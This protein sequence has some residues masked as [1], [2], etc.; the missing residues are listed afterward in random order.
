[1]TRF[2]TLAAGLMLAALLAAPSLVVAQPDDSGSTTTD[3]ADPFGSDPSFP[4]DSFPSDSSDA[5]PSDM[6]FDPDSGE[7]T[8][9]DEAFDQ[10]FNEDFG[11]APFDP[12]APPDEAIKA[13]LAVYGIAI[14]FGL[15]IG[16]AILALVCWLVSTPLKAIPEQYREM[17]PGQVWL[18][19]IPCFP[20]IWNF[21]VYQRI[22]KSFQN[23][24]AATGK[25]QFGDCGAQIGL[26]YA[27][28]AACSVV[29]CL[30]YLAGP[31]SLVL[32][33]IMLVKLWSLKGEVER[34][35]AG[36]GGEEG[37]RSSTLDI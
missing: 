7:F 25:T 20:L 18:L 1:M 4:T 9:D 14:V 27:I 26:W 15:I 19:M 34:D 6:T 5:F 23:Y 28:C 22:P 37:M 8:F 33:I 16:F 31:A 29:P 30:N 12:N 11:N 35:L 21:F 32:L 10:Q 24:F 36:G 3:P 17:T 13:I 2:P